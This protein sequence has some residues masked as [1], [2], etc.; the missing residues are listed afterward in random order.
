MTTE[1]KTQTTTE[2]NVLTNPTEEIMMT[3]VTPLEAHTDTTLDSIETEFELTEEQKAKLA[4][5][6]DS[7]DSLLEKAGAKKKFD[8]ATEMQARYSIGELLIKVKNILKEKQEFGKWL[9]KFVKEKTQYNVTVKTFR[10]WRFLAD[11]GSL[12]D[13]ELVGLTNVYRL[14]EG[15]YADA[16]VEVKAHL[17]NGF[18]K[19]GEKELKNTVRKIVSDRFHELKMASNANKADTV[20]NLKAEIKSLQLQL[21]E[22]NQAA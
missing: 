2:T 16:R 13:C 21:A 22:Q 15:N 4:P 6:V 1:L 10:R 19:G 11:F 7:M 3:N 20:R 8:A 5:I 14:M 17:A 9:Q 18:P 12:E